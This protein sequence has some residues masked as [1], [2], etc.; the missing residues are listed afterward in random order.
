V[1]STAGTGYVEL[2]ASGAVAGTTAAVAARRRARWADW[3][4]GDD[5]ERWCRRVIRQG[6]VYVRLASRH[7]SGRFCVECAR[8]VLG[9]RVRFAPAGPVERSPSCC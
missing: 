8:R 3:S 2:R 7:E 5:R 6:E 9:L 1:V 4:F